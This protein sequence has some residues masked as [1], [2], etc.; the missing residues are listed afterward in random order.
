VTSPNLDN[1]TNRKMITTKKTVGYA[2]ITIVVIIFSSNIDSITCSS[3]SEEVEVVDAGTQNLQF[4]IDSMC[5]CEDPDALYNKIVRQI[6]ND[7]GQ[8]GKERFLQEFRPKRVC[9]SDG[10]RYENGCEFQCARSKNHDSDLQPVRGCRKRINRHGPKSAKRKSMKLQSERKSAPLK[11]KQEEENEPAPAVPEQPQHLEYRPVCICPRHLFPVCASNGI[12]YGN[13]CA[14][15]CAKDNM[16]PEL[17]ITKNGR[18]N[19]DDDR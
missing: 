13:K 5:D 6:L 4:E 19:E 7:Q 2:V 17:I 3:A 11:L 18:C 8:D 12:T 16:D 15:K 10:N 1:V 9:G 14:F